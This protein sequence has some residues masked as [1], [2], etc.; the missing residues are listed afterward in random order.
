MPR[1]QSDLDIFL[2]H[3]TLTFIRKLGQGAMG[4]VYLCHNTKTGD[5][6]AV[7]EI[8]WSKLNAGN[9]AYYH[10]EVKLME[11]IGVHPYIVNPYYS[12]RIAESGFLELEYIEGVMMDTLVDIY[13]KTNSLF[14]IKIAKTLL[15]GLEYLHSKHI[16][17]RDIN[18]NNVMICAD[19][20]DINIPFKTKI[21]D[22]GIGCLIGDDIASCPNDDGDG[23]VGQS[24]FGWPYSVEGTPAEKTLMCNDIWL[25]GSVLYQL[26]YGIDFRFFDTEGRTGF[27]ALL[28]Q[29]YGIPKN[30]GH[31]VPPD[32]RRSFLKDRAKYLDPDPDLLKDLT[33]DQVALVKMYERYVLKPSRDPVYDFD[34]Q[35][36]SIIH[37]IL[38]LMLARE[39]KTCFS[40]TDLLKYITEQWDKAHIFGVYPQRKNVD[41]CDSPCEEPLNNY[42]EHNCKKCAHCQ[43]NAEGVKVKEHTIHCSSIVPNDRTRQ[44][45][46]Y[47]L[48][49]RPT[50][51]E[52]YIWNPYRKTCE[53]VIDESDDY[54]TQRFS[55]LYKDGAKAPVSGAVIRRRITSMDHSALDNDETILERLKMFQYHLLMTP[56]SLP[57]FYEFFNNRKA[58]RHGMDFS[59]KPCLTEFCQLADRRLDAQMEKKLKEETHMPYVLNTSTNRFTYVEPPARTKAKPKI[60]KTKQPVGPS[61]LSQS[62]T[63]KA[64]IV[65]KPQ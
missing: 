11:T 38:R 65:K 25:A 45:R 52:A 22:L 37:E 15:E 5:L 33:P 19:P 9:K 54:L 41:N 40:A 3:R 26:A 23:G 44:A 2:K 13:K 59:K 34:P 21:I 4:T 7:K 36:H 64:K 46:E 10:R 51:H 57:F 8:K 61:K 31:P 42:Y 29:G 43:W 12:A 48:S 17:H 50:K 63:A 6:R 28:F 47:C 58:G 20:T 24:L 14:F 30:G 55:I 53:S 27:Q 56:P 16:Y 49:R 18:S 32:L 60:T 1:R 35:K 62:S 39:V